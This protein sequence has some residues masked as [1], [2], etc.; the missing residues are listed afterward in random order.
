M[1]RKV[2]GYVSIRLLQESGES[3][4]YLI[5]TRGRIP[6]GVYDVEVSWEKPPGRKEHDCAQSYDAVF[7]SERHRVWKFSD[8]ENEADASC[9][10][11][12]CPYCGEK[13]E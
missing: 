5:H 4:G 3:P 12:F 1:K 6:D 2:A 7:Y 10:I 11:Q 9:H 8:C 13:L